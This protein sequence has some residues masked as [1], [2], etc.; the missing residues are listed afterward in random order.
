MTLAPQ[1]EAAKGDVARQLHA[2]CTNV[3]FFYVKGHGQSMPNALMCYQ[4]H[5]CHSNLRL[6]VQVCQ[7]SSALA[8]YGR[9]GSGSTF[10]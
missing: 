9:P 2:A 4:W 3:G 5:S 7:R 8:S 6:T 1:D 10:L